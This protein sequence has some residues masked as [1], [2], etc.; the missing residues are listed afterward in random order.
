MAD[1]ISVDFGSLSN[2]E[3]WLR[4]SAVAQALDGS[5]KYPNPPVSVAEV[6]SRVDAFHDAIV[7]AKGANQGSEMAMAARDS[8]RAE[9]ISTL[10]LIAAYMQANSGGDLSDS[11]F[12]TVSSTRKPPQPVTTA[13]F[14]WVKRGPPDR[15][16]FGLHV[17]KFR[18]CFQLGVPSRKTVPDRLNFALHVKKF[19]QLFP[20]WSSKS[21][22]SA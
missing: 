9:M 1:R 7:N 11:G 12:E 4:G 6:K 10:K 13:K 15:S 5:T 3:L 22:S 14:R 19:R 17:R 21:R 16:N 2:N 8:L 20:T 18:H